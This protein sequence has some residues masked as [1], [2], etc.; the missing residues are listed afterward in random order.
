MVDL[1]GE[2]GEGDVDFSS[3]WIAHGCFCFGL[4]WEEQVRYGRRWMAWSREVEIVE[5]F[6]YR[7][8]R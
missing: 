4:G 7:S 8:S 6:D 3:G 5:S 1:F 2:E